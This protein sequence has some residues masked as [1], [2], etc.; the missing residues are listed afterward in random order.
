MSK[1]ISIILSIIA[2][3]LNLFQVSQEEI[4]TVDFMSYDNTVIA[5]C[6]VKAGES[7]ELPN[8]PRKSGSSFLGWQGNYIN[9]QKDETV[10]AIFDDEKNV[11][12][13]SSTNGN[14]GDTVTLLISLN[15]NVETCGFDMTINYDE[16]L[17][18][19]SCDYDL[20]LDI[21]ANAKAGEN[22]IVGPKVLGKI[23]VSKFESD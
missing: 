2:L 15:G 9:V 10:K 23:D 11:F 3:V 1:V 8:A 21:V 16:A 20:D 5:S 13:V 18:L 4:F 22:K 12:M 6:E 17:E 7:A 14:I 19:V